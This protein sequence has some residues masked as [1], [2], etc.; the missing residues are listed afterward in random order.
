MPEEVR[1]YTAQ[2][3]SSLSRAELE[4]FYAQMRG[5]WRAR[6]SPLPF[7]SVGPLPISMPTGFLLVH[8]SDGATA[9]VLVG[10][11]NPGRSGTLIQV[12]ILPP[13]PSPSPTPR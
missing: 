13:R 12:T 3:D 10:M 2:W 9:S 8:E 5:T 1:G 4:G 6:G 7:P 11:T